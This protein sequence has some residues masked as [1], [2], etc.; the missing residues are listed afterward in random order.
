MIS[1]EQVNKTI[2]DLRSY[3]P[4]MR[5]MKMH[6]VADDYRTAALLIEEL[7]ALCDEK[8]ATI[9]DLRNQL[10]TEALEKSYKEQRGFEQDGEVLAYASD[11]S[12]TDTSVVRGPITEQEVGPFYALMTKVCCEQ[13]HVEDFH[14]LL[15]SFARSRGIL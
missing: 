10:E 8:D 13:S 4:G 2:G 7:Q 6:L 3:E 1:R 12:K 14:Y 15:E 11:G 9:D 5:R